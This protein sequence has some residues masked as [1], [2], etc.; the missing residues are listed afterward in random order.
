MNFLRQEGVAVIL[1]SRSGWPGAVRG[2]G[3]PGTKVDRWARKES[4]ESL[5]IV[6][7][8]PEHYNRMYRI[9][10]REL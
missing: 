1:E 4:L 8:T 9:L 7:V 6:A 10:Q 5:P 2:F 3:R